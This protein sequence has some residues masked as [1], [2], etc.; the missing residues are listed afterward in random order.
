VQGRGGEK[1]YRLLLLARRADRVRHHRVAHRSDVL[2]V[3]HTQPLTA[4]EQRIDVVMRKAHRTHADQDAA[5]S[6]F[7]LAQLQRDKREVLLERTADLLLIRSSV[8]E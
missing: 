1:R 5:L 7:R 2:A 4:D 3:R 8:H 6:L